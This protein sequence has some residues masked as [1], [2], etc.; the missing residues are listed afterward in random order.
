MLRPDRVTAVREYVRVGTSLLMT[1]SVQP[2]LSVQPAVYRPQD[3]TLLLGRVLTRTLEQLR[4]GSRADRCRVLELGTG[5]GYLAVRAATHPGVDVTAVDLADEA[6]AAAGAEAESHGVA[7]RLLW[8]DLTAPV[9]GEQFDV[10]FS[11]PPYV[12]AEDPEVPR[13][14]PARAWD[15]GLDGRA[16]LDRLCREVPRV[17][18]PGGTVL[19]VQSAL[20]DA[21]ATRAMLEAEGMVTEVAARCVLPFGPVLAERVDYLEGVGL[22]DPGCRQEELVVIRGHR[23]P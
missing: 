7:V 3:D 9:T 17:L 18:A 10:V 11:N 22:V 12:P 5:S 14:G 4:A 15:A 13:D 8:G 6:L 1:L 16:V 23:M 21:D 19:I 20:A 2:S